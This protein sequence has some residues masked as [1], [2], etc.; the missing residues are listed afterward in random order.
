VAVL[1]ILAAAA[2]AVGSAGG[3]SRVLAPL[4]VKPLRHSFGAGT[5]LAHRDFEFESD[6]EDAEHPIRL[7]G[8]WFPARSDR[9][10]APPRRPLIVFLHGHNANR[11]ESLETVR[12]LTA[13]GYEV[14]AYDSRGHGAS[15]GEFCTFGAFE[16]RDLVR[17]LDAAGAHEVIVIGTSLGAAVALQ[18]APSE[19]RIR[20]IIAHAPFVDLRTAIGDRSR[21]LP[22]ALVL[23]ASR[24]AERLAGFH[25]DDVSPLASA[26]GVRVP[27]LLLHGGEDHETPPVHS[28]RILAALGG[29]KERVVL[30][31]LGHA[32]LL[33]RPAAWTAIE[34]WLERIADAATSTSTSTAT[35]TSTSTR[36]TPP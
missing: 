29:P 12:R 15:G 4:I 30:P 11:S 16:K 22:E 7:E 34:P 2:V 13:R 8:W 23:G 31:G 27:V 36:G 19:P 33:D 28:E 25:I 6:A 9:G 3:P 35:A 10:A 24:E 18:A 1:L 17:A 20:A 21:F 32:R 5:E 26:R 14:L